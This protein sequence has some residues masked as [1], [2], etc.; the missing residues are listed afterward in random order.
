MAN[1]RVALDI[2]SKTIDVEDKQVKVSVSGKTK[3]QWSCHEGTFQ[4]KFK[5][6][7]D[8][9]NPVTSDQGGVWKAECGPFTAPNSRLE[10]A[11]ESPGYTILDPEILILP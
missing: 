7:Y 11:V 1:V 6:G 10:Y 5:P 8:W 9:P 4:I 2:V 3:V